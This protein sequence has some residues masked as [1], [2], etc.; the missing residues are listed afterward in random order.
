[1]FYQDRIKS[2]IRE[3]SRGPLHPLTGAYVQQLYDHGYADGTIC[4]YLAAL[5][6]LSYWLKQESNRATPLTP[7]VLDQFLKAR[8]ANS[9]RGERAAWR[10][11]KAQLS[12][13]PA[14]QA[15]HSEV[16]SQELQ[17]F[18]HHMDTVCGL[19]PSTRV[20]RCRT[21]DA[22]LRSCGFAS[23]GEEV[24]TVAGL[25]AF[26]MPLMQRLK[27][28]SLNTV[29]VHLRSY[30][31]F[32][33]LQGTPT[34]VLLAS[35]PKV[36]VWGQGALPRVLSEAQVGHFLNA[37]DL[38]DP[39]QLRDYAIARCL[40][41]L[42][43]R[44]EEATLLALDD[45]DW[46]RGIVT[47]VES[48]SRRAQQLPLPVTTGEAVAAYLK[49]ARP[50]TAERRLFVRHRAPRGVPLTVAAIRSA[51]NRAFTRCGLRSQ[52]CNTH[53]LRR[54]AAT[55]MQCA[56]ASVKAI[57]DLLRHQTLDTARVYARV[58]IEQLRTIALPW[59]GALS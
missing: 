50:Q 10:R 28:S 54:T 12:A 30:F 21:V 6:E 17:H 25:E 1:M 44:G 27:P 34:A 2:S 18:V 43:L 11:L 23:S 36:A 47:L 57:A 16:V 4:Q 48:K 7:A 45:L 51:M 32:R 59:P 38:A 24:L 33:A 35:L 56:G 20:C 26:L 42:G 3:L 5:V 15:S 46:R 39:V 8:Q 22:F 19:A 52:F 14:A 49:Q 41:D 37:F 40:L 13:Q 29:L 55:R 31:R 58:D 53:V 9:S